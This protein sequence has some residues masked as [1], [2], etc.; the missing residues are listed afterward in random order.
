MIHLELSVSD[1]T[2][3]SINLELSV[4]ILEA[5]LSLICDTYGKGITY[6]DHQLFIVQ[7]SGKQD[8]Q[9]MFTPKQPL[10]FNN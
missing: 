8:Y 1:A 6:N 3:W 10:I 4:M 9:L 7:V 2:I 5:S